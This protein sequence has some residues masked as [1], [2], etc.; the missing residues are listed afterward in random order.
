MPAN[1][2]EYFV[3]RTNARIVKLLDENPEISQTILRLLE[4]MVEFADHKGVSP[5]KLGIHDAVIHQD[6]TFQGR[7][8]KL[9]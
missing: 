4:E 8:V 9:R 5:R 3:G 6:G 2:Y 1:A 7:I